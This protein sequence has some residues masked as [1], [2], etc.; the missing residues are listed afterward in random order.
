MA[1]S[2]KPGC[3]IDGEIALGLPPD[4]RGLAYGDG[5]FETILLHHGQ[6]VWWQAH[7]ARMRL[8]ADRLGIVAPEDASWAADLEQ[9]LRHAPPQPREILKLLLTRGS[10]GRGYLAPEPASPRR[11]LLRLPAPTDEACWRRDGVALHD[12]ATRLALQPALAG[13]KHLNR[14]EQVLARSEW[15]DPALI[16]GL[17]RDADGA[18]VCATAANLFIVVD[19]QLGTPL[20][21]RCGVAGVCRRFLLEQ[22]GASECRLTAEMLVAADEVFVCSSVRGIL[23]VRA[24]A[25]L[26]WRVGPVTRRLLRRL[27]D[28]QPAFAF[29]DLA[30]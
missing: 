22:A 17:M 6:P 15:R 24:L 25:E 11:I 21:D 27:A 9:M 30:E 16:E 8:G 7:L 5:L 19:G 28:A 12:C 1:D 23:P 29:S 14:L 10:G 18:P 2:R 26:R 13:L 20:V 4:D 3:L